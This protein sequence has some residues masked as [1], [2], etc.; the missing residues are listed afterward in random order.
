MAQDA[1]YFA[2][3]SNMNPARMAERTGHLGS[4]IRALLRGFRLVFNKRSTSADTVFAN[5][6]PIHEAVVWGVLY[7]CTPAAL[8]LLDKCEGVA[9]GNYYRATV[10]VEPDD[11]PPQE[12][13][14]YIAG[15]HFVTSERH[16]TAK[17]LAHILTGAKVHQ[18][19]EEYIGQIRAL[20]GNAA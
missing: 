12:A 6:E 19:P 18:V 9:T 1:L 17:Y 5:I 7:R 10:T 8:D 2:Y 4:G 16:P 11:A 15:P 13:I 14:T 3:G 20:A